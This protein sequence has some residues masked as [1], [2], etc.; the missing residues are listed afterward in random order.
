M[1]SD[2]TKSHIFQQL[3]SIKNSENIQVGQVQTTQKLTSK[4][5]ETHEDFHHRILTSTTKN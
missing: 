5:K 1:A 4:K 2:A 3:F